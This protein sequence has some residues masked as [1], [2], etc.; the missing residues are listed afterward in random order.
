MLGIAKQPGKTAA[1]ASTAGELC[2][3]GTHAP[4]D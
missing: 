2:H 3:F 4:P 1:L